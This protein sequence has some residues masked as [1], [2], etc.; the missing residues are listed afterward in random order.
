[1]WTEAN[2]FAPVYS[3]VS[4][5]SEQRWPYRTRGRTP[6][7]RSCNARFRAAPGTKVD[8]IAIVSYENQHYDAD[9]RW[10]TARQRDGT[11][12]VLHF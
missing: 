4:Y 10:P 7:Q 2:P 6:R 11:L 3:Y 9:V 12:N 8:D 5:Q 1:M